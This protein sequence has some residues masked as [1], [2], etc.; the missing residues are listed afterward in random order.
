MQSV[1][2]RKVYSGGKKH[3]KMIFMLDK[4]AV[5]EI[6]FVNFGINC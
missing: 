5:V 3:R 2:R 6:H 4:K 1:G